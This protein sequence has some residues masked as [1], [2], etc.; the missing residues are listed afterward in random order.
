V[1]RGLSD[2]PAVELSTAS[3]VVEEHPPREVL[4]LPESS[5][6][7]GG[8]HFTWLNDDTEWMWPLIHAAERRMEDLVTRFPDSDGT[9][10]DILNQTA[11][12]LL[13]LQSSDWPFLV[14]TLQAKEYA[15]E[16]FQEHLERYNQL[17]SLSEADTYSTEDKS[18]LAA[19][20]ERD[21]PFATIDYR[22][23]APRQGY[24]GVPPAVSTA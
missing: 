1:L 22:D 20:R 7:A 11:R 18:Y 5:W 3:R 16:R 24:A 2:R 23:W 13:L 12:E 15:V 19:L 6:G 17:A 4:S 8:G 9:R 10:R 14:T 21:N